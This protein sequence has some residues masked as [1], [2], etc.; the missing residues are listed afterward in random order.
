[1]NTPRKIRVLIVDDCTVVGRVIAHALS[2]DPEI[3]VV[4]AACDPYVARDKILQLDPD[5]LTLD[6]QMPRMDGLTFLRILQQHHP[7]PVIIISAMTQAGSAA[8]LEALA[9]GAVDVLP[10]PSSSW[11]IGRLREQL[12]GRIKAAF[13]ARLR[14]CRPA[15]AANASSSL[16]ASPSGLHS[17]QIVLIGAST[18]GTEAIK[19]VLTRLPPGLPGIC[20]VQHIPPIFSKAFA[21]R[22]AQCCP[23]EVREAAHGDKVQCGLALIAPGNYHML[24]GFRW[25]LLS[26][27]T[28][29]KPSLAPHPAGRGPSL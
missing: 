16:A 19:S 11:S 25:R 5:V 17:R 29:P 3:E 9:A 26:S 15:V 12:P 22:L 27:A 2:R 4:G 10:K 21:R 14:N 24:V 1:M 18:G 6:I 7:L 20:I 8:A 28:E 23:F 13:A